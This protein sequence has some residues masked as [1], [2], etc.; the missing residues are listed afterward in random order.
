MSISPA[1]ANLAVKAAL[2]KAESLDITVCVAVLDAGGRLVA[3]ARMDKSNWASIYGSQGKALTSAATGYN[4]DGIPP[5]SNVMQRI[6]ELEGNNMIYAKGA[7]PISRDG[8]L[9]GA[10]GV[11]GGNADDDELCAQ[12]GADAVVKSV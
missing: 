11:G 6:A 4:S 7:V 3:F 8:I 1:D 9:I 5:T 2:D 10:I 12:T